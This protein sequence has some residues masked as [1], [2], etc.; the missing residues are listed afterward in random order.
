MHT[1]VCVKIQLLLPLACLLASCA[2]APN[3]AKQNYKPNYDTK[4]SSPKS[5]TVSVLKYDFTSM[6]G[7][8]KW[9]IQ[10]QNNGLI[11]LGT[12]HYKTIF[13]PTD[14]RL[15]ELASKEG[16][17][18]VYFDIE[19]SGTRTIK[20]RVPLGGT[21][22]TV[23]YNPSYTGGVG[24]FSYNPGI[25]VYGYENAEINENVIAIWFFRKA[26]TM[27]QKELDALFEEIDKKRE[28]LSY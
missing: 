1:F 6:E 24:T 7:F 19:H 15:K 27:N 21:E 22:D 18:M 11:W 12:S 2:S 16:A 26:S 28:A 5:N 8:K 13:K 3:L 4:L 9:V 23:R 10:K 25:K 20:K 14:E 17:D